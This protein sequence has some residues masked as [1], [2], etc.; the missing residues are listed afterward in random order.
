MKRKIDDD[1]AYI[2]VC[3]YVR[4]YTCVQLEPM[5]MCVLMRKTNPI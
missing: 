1:G 4:V 3:V 2:C 5:A